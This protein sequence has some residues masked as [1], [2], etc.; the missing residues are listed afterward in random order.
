[1]RE[2]EPVP[3]AQ[4][5]PSVRPQVVRAIERAMAKDPAA[6]PATAAEMAADLG[7]AP[8]SAGIA[9]LAS[10]AGTTTVALD[11]LAVAGPPR[12]RGLPIGLLVAGALIA[13]ALAFAIGA[14][15]THRSGAASGSTT[16]IQDNAAM[17]AKIDQ[18]AISVRDDPSTMSSELA[19]RLR[20]L[21][22]E[23]RA[24]DQATTSD[25]NALLADAA[26]WHQQGERVLSTSAYSRTAALLTTL[27]GVQAPAA[28]TTT[29]AVA[30]T[31][32]APAPAPK[33]HKGK[34][35]G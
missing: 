33:K 18:L 7:I 10:N 30:P 31:T 19:D 22:T 34:A 14:A 3:L 6:R 25:A 16:T 4:L 35:D 29:T 8:A 26:R 13:F 24:G 2:T 32:V 21:A 15:L 20:A 11:A 17:A 23:V 9:T 27:P 1:V 5:N 12:R 28:A